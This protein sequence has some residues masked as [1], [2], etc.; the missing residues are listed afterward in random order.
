M[1]ADG[2]VVGLSLHDSVGVSVGT[3]LLVA[4]E[5]SMNDAVGVGK[6]RLRGGVVMLGGLQAGLGLLRVALLLL[7][8]SLPLLLFVELL[9][10]GGIRTARAVQVNLVARLLERVVHLD[11][12]L[13]QIVFVRV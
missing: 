8:L 1:G 2:S 4:L 12:S 9:V 3:W 11:G 7:L 6:R 10:G 5:A 13:F